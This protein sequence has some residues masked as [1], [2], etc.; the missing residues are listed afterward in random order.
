M[1][2]KWIAKAVKSGKKGKL[3]KE[4]G[5]KKG[6]PIAAKKLEKAE[7]SK[8]PKLKKE[9]VMAKTLRGMRK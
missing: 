1:A 9:A 7:H 4:L 3:R 8:N 5:A 6:K 2:E